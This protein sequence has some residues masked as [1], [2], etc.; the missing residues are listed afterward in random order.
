MMSRTCWSPCKVF[1]K[2]I[3]QANICD[4]CI[5]KLR[6]E[7]QWGWRDD[8]I[9]AAFF[10]GPKNYST[11]DTVCVKSLT[12]EEKEQQMEGLQRPYL[13]FWDKTILRLLP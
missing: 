12:L 13:L 6:Q 9:L 5:F 7:R 1:E 4:N 10:R 3:Y 11:V 2:L 8:G